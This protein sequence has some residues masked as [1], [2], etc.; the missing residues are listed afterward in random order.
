MLLKSVRDNDGLRIDANSRIWYNL[1]S[2]YT[3]QTS[4][5]LLVLLENFV[6]YFVYTQMIFSVLL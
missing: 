4:Q 2:I 5:Y 3:V 1:M 6:G